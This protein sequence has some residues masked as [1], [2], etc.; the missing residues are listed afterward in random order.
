MLAADFTSR[1]PGLSENT[2]DLF[3]RIT[4]LHREALTLLMK[5]L[6][7]LRCI[8]QR[9]AGQEDISAVAINVISVSEN[10]IVTV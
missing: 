1:N 9:G 3:V 10:G 2:D 7:T 8:N 5:I 4:L 6:L